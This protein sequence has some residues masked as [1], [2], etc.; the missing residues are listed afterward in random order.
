MNNKILFFSV[1]F[2]CLSLCSC[3]T[4]L[5]YK[6]NQYV[7]QCKARNM[8]NI[9]LK[10]ADTVYCYS[11]GFN[12]FY[13]I[14]YHKDDCLYSYYVRPCKTVKYKSQKVRNITIDKQ[15]IDKYS[16]ENERI[17]TH[18][19]ILSLDGEIIDIYF[20]NKEVIT[21][22]IDSDCLFTTKFAYNSFPYKLQYDISRIWKTKKLDFEKLY[23]DE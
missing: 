23:S 1:I 6:S 2:I 19:F 15:E 4:T 12:N 14:W 17:D 11:C 9:F 16:C 20:N 22:P 10:R 18:C 21:I 7:L 13:L 8:I 5:L 3:N